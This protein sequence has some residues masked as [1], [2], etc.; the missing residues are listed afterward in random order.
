MR[1]TKRGRIVVWSLVFAAAFAFGV[2]T[3][4][5]S[6]DYSHGVPQVYDNRDLSRNTDRP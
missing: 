6:I 2:L 5:V 1:L 3:A 4:P